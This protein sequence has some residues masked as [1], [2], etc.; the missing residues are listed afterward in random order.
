[1]GSTVYAT[2][3]QETLSISITMPCPDCKEILRKR[4]Q[5]LNNTRVMF[6]Q[7]MITLGQHVCVCVCV[8]VCCAHVCEA[9][10]YVPMESEDRRP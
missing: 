1:M 9:V 10:V 3:R 7:C 5:H 2:L 8:C 4:N 6:T